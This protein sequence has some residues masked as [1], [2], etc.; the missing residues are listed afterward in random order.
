MATQKFNGNSKGFSLGWDT[1]DVRPAVAKSF[2]SNKIDPVETS[3]RGHKFL[4]KKKLD[5]STKVGSSDLKVTFTE[6]TPKI[7]RN[8]F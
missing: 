6:S 2:L 4:E 3:T 8:V 1:P 5:V 7:T